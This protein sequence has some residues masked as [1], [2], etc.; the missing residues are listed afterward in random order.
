[1]YTTVGTTSLRTDEKVLV[2]V[3]AADPRSDWVH[4]FS[5]GRLYLTDRRLVLRPWAV[6]DGA[7]CHPWELSVDAVDRVSSA[8]VP[9]WLFGLV[10]IW[11]H[12]IRIVT[13][14]GKAKTIIMGRTG[15]AECV[16][17]LDGILRARRRSC[18]RTTA[19]SSS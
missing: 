8:P 14:D 17:T 4:G 9:V 2:Q 12:G 19:S 11:L 3:M 7:G 18:E 16:A 6:L 1:M 15:A 10:R 13:L 5:S